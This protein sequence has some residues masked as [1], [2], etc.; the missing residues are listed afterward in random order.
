MKTVW[1]FLILVNSAT[2]Q[3]F[4]SSSWN[5]KDSEVTFVV[6]AP[7][8]ATV[9]TGAPY[10]ADEIQEYISPD[11]TSSPRSTVV[12]HFARDGAGRSRMERA[13]KPAPIWLTEIFDPVAGV[14]YLLDDQKKVAHRMLMPPAPVTAAPPANPRATIEKLDSQTIEGVLVEGKRTVF[15]IPGNTP[16]PALTIE[17]WEA[18]ELKLTL[19]TKSSNG[20]T[21][22]LTG[23][24]RNQPDS[25]LFRPPADYSVVYESAPFPMAIQFSDRAR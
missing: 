24:N 19:L 10:S 13:Y 11:G 14:A 15:E 8:P 25:A 21:T 22:R 4:S 2:A 7:R 16:R 18:P 5:V 17:T 23:L 20:Y 12:G 6:G 1:I 3:Q 9:I